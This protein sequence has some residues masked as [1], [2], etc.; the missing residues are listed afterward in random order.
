MERKIKGEHL[1]SNQKLSGTYSGRSGVQARSWWSQAQCPPRVFHISASALPKYKSRVELFHRK[2][3]RDIP[4]KGWSSD[5]TASPAHTVSLLLPPTPLCQAS[6]CVCHPLFL[7]S[8]YECSFRSLHSPHSLI[9]I[10][11]LTDLVNSAP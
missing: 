7:S 10:G 11:R 8:E 2:K 4:F 5:E 9:S 3:I 6:F 1:D